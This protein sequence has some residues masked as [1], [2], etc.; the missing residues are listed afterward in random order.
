M[1][2]H[3]VFA[4]IYQLFTEVLFA[5]C[6]SQPPLI[7]P[8]PAQAGLP[9]P[10]RSFRKSLEF[11]GDGGDVSTSRPLGVALTLASLLCPTGCQVDTANHI[12]DIVLPNESHRFGRHPGAV[13]V[14]CLVTMHFIILSHTLT[15]TT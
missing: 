2:K 4:A 6:L 5:R 8:A 12:V 10:R 9:E 11:K 7:K 3:V 14:V 15:V 13:H 1:H